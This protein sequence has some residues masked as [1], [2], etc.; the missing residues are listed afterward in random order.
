[1]ASQEGK[2]GYETVDVQGLEGS[3]RLQPAAGETERRV[4]QGAVLV[5]LF[6][7]FIAVVVLPGAE[8]DA[9]PT[10]V[11]FCLE[12]QPAAW[13]LTEDTPDFPPSDTVTLFTNCKIWT[14]SA[15]GTLEA[16]SLL[17]SAGKIAAIGAAAARAAPAGASSYD[18]QGAWLTPGII[19]IH[20][21]LGVGAY[22][23]D[24][25]GHGDTNEYAASGPGMGGIESMVRALDGVDP[26]DPAIPQIRS[27]GVTTSQVLPG[28]GNMM[29]GESYVLKMKGGAN[30][31]GATVQNQ[32]LR[33]ASRGLKMACGENPKRATKL[34][35]YSN[36]PDT[37]MGAAWKMREQFQKAQDLIDAQDDWD[38]AC[39][40]GERQTA[41]RPKDLSL[42]SVAALLRGEAT[43]HNHCYQVHDMEMMIR[44]SHEFGF[45]INAF[46]HT[47]EAYKM[48]D[49]LAEE[50]IAAATWPDDWVGKAE[51]FDT[52]FHAPAW[53]V[54]RG[55]TLV[56]KSDHPVT[57]AK[58]LM[59]GAARAVH[60]GL[61]VD[62]ALLSLTLNPAR[63][64]KLEHR[65]GSIEVGKD[66]DVVVWDRHPLALGAKPRSVFIEGDEL[67]QA[68]RLPPPA[69]NAPRQAENA[70][71]FE[72]EGSSCTPPEH[73][74]R[75]AEGGVVEIDT[76]AVVG[77][78]IWTMQTSQPIRN[79][80]V[81]VQGGIVS[82][83][84]TMST[85]GSELQRV[86]VSQRFSTNGQLWAGML[87]VGDGIG[88]YEMGEP[89]TH[90]GPLRGSP[91]DMLDVW[92]IEGMRTGGRHMWEAWRGGLS[93]SVTPP[94]GS[95]MIRG[96]SSAMWV[97]PHGHDHASTTLKSVVA[98]HIALGN[99][100]RAGGGLASS[101]SGQLFQ[102]RKWL[103]SSGPSQLD[104]VRN[105]SAPLVL[106]VDQAD[107]MSQ[108]LRLVAEVAPNARLTIFGGAEAHLIVPEIV[109]ATNIQAVVLSPPRPVPEARFDQDRAPDPLKGDQHAAVTL[110]QAGIKVGL[111]GAAGPATNLRWEAGL[112]M[113]AGVPR[114]LA[115]QM[116]TRNLAEAMGL[117]EGIGT[118]SVGQRAHFALYTAD[119][120]AIDSEIALVASGGL[121]S[122][123]PPATPWDLAWKPTGPTGIP[124][125]A[126]LSSGR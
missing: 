88:Q 21:H 86:P 113:D 121:L 68:G 91:E 2:R 107:A 42:D 120:L 44:L 103:R 22:P 78:D 46:H 84:G 102:L 125:G 6:A 90:D 115:M 11:D 1:M 31:N 77:A 9:V 16:A 59:Y 126:D 99:R 51:G 87:S 109:A 58:E 17:V 34:E 8:V 53:I 65:I 56:L 45:K 30:V 3:P 96:V 43:L 62:D 32:V 73:S 55:A 117:S 106:H 28:S 93:I 122:C 36:F 60:Y 20:S 89:P 75:V 79:G 104:G 41:R 10:G 70:A 37:R 15:A 64:L 110:S 100:A 72:L 39:A 18:C 50:D 118:I 26:E 7:I 80:V 48:A 29:G 35:Y 33:G 98:V 123:Y 101:V 4:F 124:E 38:S 97:S 24:W 76:Y 105:G 52:S 61:G 5:L 12:E 111:A 116:A 49:R 25:A 119:P 85:C 81:T 40:A 27:G 54:E 82:C 47:L 95:S 92:A 108:A 67:F 114:Y 69:F 57:D 66:A 74:A 63:T 19:D 71:E 23:T 13:T 14:G 83:V 94:E 112:A